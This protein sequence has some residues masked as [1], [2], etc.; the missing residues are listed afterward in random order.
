MK[1]NCYSDTKTSKSNE[2]IIFRKAT[3]DPWW[4][5]YE[6]FW[7]RR[8]IFF[9]FWRNVLAWFRAKK[10]FQSK[11]VSGEWWGCTDVT[12]LDNKSEILL[13]LFRQRKI[14]NRHWVNRQ[15]LFILCIDFY[16]QW[17]STWWQE[18]NMAFE[19]LSKY[20]DRVMKYKNIVHIFSFIEYIPYGNK[21]K[22]EGGD[23]TIGKSIAVFLSKPALCFTFVINIKKTFFFIPCSYI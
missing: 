22:K 14:S 1:I 17:W 9:K 20:V 5:I 16:Y 19:T 10:V 8:A 6:W 15:F 23:S 11:H 4:S 7:L 13:P 3:S 12:G 2:Q 18:S 21:F